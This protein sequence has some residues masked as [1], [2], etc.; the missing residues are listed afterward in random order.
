MLEP[1]ITID[2]GTIG[3]RDV[4]VF[5]NLTLTIPKGEV[6]AL[7]GPNGCGKSTALKAMRGLLPLTAGQILMDAMPLAH[8]DAKALARAVAMLGQTPSAPEE[9]R[10]RD[11]VA[12]GRYAH[13]R[14][15]AGLTGC[16]HAAIEAAI[17]ATDMHALADTALANLSGGQ[18]QRAWLAMVLAQQSPVIFLDE[19]TNHLDITHALSTLSLVRTMARDAGKT[20]VIVLHD[21]NMAATF[22]DRIVLFKDG[23][24]A[25]DGPVRAVLTAETVEAVFDVRCAV[26][27]RPESDLPLIVPLFAKTIRD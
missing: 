1:L 5:Q 21:L 2:A 22:A 23:K 12:L 7:C 15:F 16:D 3:Y 27:Q 6:T 10:V 8:W 11:L 9:M 20:V 18:A 13:R 26:L 25:A 17:R 19:P 24:I 14:P 4:P